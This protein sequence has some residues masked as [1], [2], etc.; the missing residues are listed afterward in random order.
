[1]R[2]EFENIKVPLRIQLSGIWAS[3]MCCYI[4]G[5][6]F[7]LYVPGK[8]EGLISGQHLL[9]T[10][11]KLFAA[12]LIMALPSLMIFLSLILSPKP[13]RWLNIGAG[14][15]FTL[16]TFWVGISSLTMWHTFYVFLSFLESLLTLLIVVK[17]WKW[18]RITQP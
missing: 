2:N 6:Y 9:D 16:F 1:M 15:F 7:E 3:V 5:D 14:V 13:A 4:Y 11:M 8:V 10:P 17:A 18:P 12:S